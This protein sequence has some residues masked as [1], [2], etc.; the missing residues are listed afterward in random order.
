MA[1]GDHFVEHHVEREDICAR[2]GG[3]ALQL[4]GRRVSDR[5][6]DDARASLR[7]TAIH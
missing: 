7:L 6:E 2:V 4:L 5:A 1:A 3:L